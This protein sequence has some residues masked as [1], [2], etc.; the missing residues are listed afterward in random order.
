MR[1]T[2]Y[3]LNEQIVYENEILNIL[4]N[5][6]L[7]IIDNCGSELSKCKLAKYA[8]DLKEKSKQ[9]QI[10]VVSFQ[11]EIISVADKILG[12]IDNDKLVGINLNDT[13]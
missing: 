10:I 1:K 11:E 12:V 3:I 5:L 13:N 8:K 6:K 2:S 9:E 4:E 7:T